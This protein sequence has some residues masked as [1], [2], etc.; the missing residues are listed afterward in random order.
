MIPASL[1][2]TTVFGLSTTL[3]VAGLLLGNLAV[4]ASPGSAV[5]E[6]QI[7]D[8]HQATAVCAER[9][10]H[11]YFGHHA[12]NK[13]IAS[14]TALTNCRIAHPTQPAQCAL[15]EL[16]GKAVTTMADIREHLPSAP[17]PL[18]LWKISNDQIGSPN[19]WLAGSIHL[20]KPGF[21][22]LP[23][24]FE[25]AYR[26]SKHLV[27]EVDPD[28]LD[29]VRVQR[30]IAKYA[31]LPDKQQLSH[32]MTPDSLTDLSRHIKDFG[33]S[34]SDF[35]TMKPAYLV[36]QLAV[37]EMMALNY[38]PNLGMESHFAKLHAPGPIKA[39]ET[40]EFQLKLLF[41]PDNPTQV[42]LAEEYLQQAKDF[43][44][45]I[46]D[47]QIA[48]LSGD[49]AA[50]LKI[51]AEQEGQ[52]AGVR[53]Y[54]KAL[55]QTRNVGMADSIETYLSRA[56]SPRATPSDPAALKDFF[57]LVGTAHLVGEANIPQLLEQRGFT[58]QRLYSNSAL[59]L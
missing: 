53:A 12:Q 31:R 50:M 48:W 11:Q 27:Q 47:M 56:T 36:Q 34:I 7:P 28:E 37:L 45:L 5:V 8:K 49:D 43:E 59:P 15:V 55:L 1:R 13:I 20:L 51:L 18:Y 41:S 4:E 26:H 44:R 39:L 10:A 29:P 35:E 58:V 52:S 21:Y 3:L 40:T 23:S 32:L 22:P 16:N 24:Q 33:L 17:H 46:V 14:Q 9:P 6:N 30:L 57:V 19:V 25:A 38:Q 2:A 54:T 42:A